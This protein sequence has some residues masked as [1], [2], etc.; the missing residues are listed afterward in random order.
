MDTS[1]RRLQKTIALLFHL[2]SRLEI[3]GAEKVPAEGGMILATNHI[4]RL[5]TPLLGISCPRRVYGMVAE[6][7]KSYP[8][9]N[10]FLKMT[11]PIWVRRSDFD[12]GALM[13]ALELLEAGKV[14]GLAPEGTRSRTASLQPGK[15][16]IAFLAAHAHVPLVPVAITG[17]EQ[18]WARFRR[19]QRM[20]VRV[21]F[22]EPFRL[23]KEGRLRSEELAEA[24]QRIMLHIAQLLP[25]AY[26]GVYADDVAQLAEAE[27][28]SAES[29]GASSG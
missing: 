13:E 28:A 1:F 25:P 8:F 24:T 19:F 15:P 20:R 4:S 17:T 16:G 2:L 22:G 26:R 27:G 9:F 11:D 21:T 23:E 6:K 29:R 5:D 14:L 18:M 10:W 3:V 7:Y 12:R